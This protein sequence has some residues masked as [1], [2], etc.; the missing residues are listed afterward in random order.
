MR[1]LI[2]L[3]GLIC[4]GAGLMAQ[5]KKPLPV[6]ATGKPSLAKG[7][8]VYTTYCLSCHQADGGGVP[9]MNPPL[10]NTPY[11]LGEK[12]RLIKIL[13]NGL[14]EEV[15]I[16]GSYYTNPMP[17]HNFL[18]DEDIA[19]VLSF[20]RNNFTNKAPVITAAEVKKVRDSKEVK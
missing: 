3:T 14:N 20:V 7:K 19:N 4:C 10:I 5:S 11:V 18:K 1:R 8:L 17:A 6:K 16:N 13:L 15:E 2:L 12:T 9:N